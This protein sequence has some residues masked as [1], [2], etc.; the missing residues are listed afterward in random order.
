MMGLI[1]SFI[2]NSGGPSADAEAGT[3]ATAMEEPA[4]Q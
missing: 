3:G 4:A 1:G 2:N